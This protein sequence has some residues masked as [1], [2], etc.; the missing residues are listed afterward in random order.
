MALFQERGPGHPEG[1]HEPAKPH[2]L[3]P[4]QAVAGGQAGEDRED[5]E[6]E[7]HAKTRPG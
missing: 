3:L 6:S 7:V 2:A 5:E 1:D 4:L